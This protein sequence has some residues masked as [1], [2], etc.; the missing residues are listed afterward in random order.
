MT[1]IPLGQLVK[2]THW[3][4][5]TSLPLS[6][7]RPHSSL[8]LRITQTLTSSQLPRSPNHLHRR[9]RT[10]A[11]SDGPRPR[12]W[13]CSKYSTTVQ[14]SVR[15]DLEDAA[16]S[17]RA[18]PLLCLGFVAVVAVLIGLASLDVL[19]L[20][21]DTL[22]MVV[23]GTTP[24]CSRFGATVN[25]TYHRA[26]MDASKCSTRYPSSPFSALLSPSSPLGSSC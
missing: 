22:V 26:T 17:A 25:G 19:M 7:H 18:R 6:A 13:S 21:D 11:N 1:K 23:V 3:L 15:V 24:A 14:L 9:R 2:L 10:P 20:L 4:N 16:S 8:P 12:C 5:R